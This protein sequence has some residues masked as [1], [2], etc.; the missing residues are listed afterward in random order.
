MVF[1]SGAEAKLRGRTDDAHAAATAV[2]DGNVPH[3]PVFRVAAA[4]AVVE[5]YCVSAALG[6]VVGL[7]ALLFVRGS[8]PAPELAATP[9]PE[10]AAWG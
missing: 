3:L 10:P 5:V 8:G 1:R 4:H 7:L 6:V 9:E 2:I